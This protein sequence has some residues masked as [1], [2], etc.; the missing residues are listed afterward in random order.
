MPNFHPQKLD[1]AR[2]PKAT[3]PNAPRDLFLQTRSG[4][5][6]QNS[7]VLH[8]LEWMSEATNPLILLHGGGAH[9]HWWDT[10]APRLLDDFRVFAL[11][12]RGHGDSDHAPGRYQPEHLVADLALVLERLAPGAAVIGASMGGHIALHAAAMGVAMRH[13]VLVD[14]PPRAPANVVDRRS[15]FGTPKIY[16]SRAEA[17]RRFRV[18]PSETSADASI[19]AEI[20]RHSIRPLDDDRYCLKFDHRMFETAPVEPPP[21]MLERVRVPV[22]LL[23]GEN[24]DI[25]DA[26]TARE[27]ARRIANCRVVT[28]PRASHHLHLDNPEGFVEAVK[29]FLTAERED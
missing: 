29:G 7:I 15:L 18:V 4:P 6:D 16:A 8:V 28:I 5:A 24:S 10:V 9:A 27:M 13:L 17:L 21:D 22:L 25:L 19:L 14:V 23:R 26:A 3:L 1:L 11:D 12:L 2:M 20:A